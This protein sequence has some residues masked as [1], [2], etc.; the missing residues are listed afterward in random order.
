MLREVKKHEM[1]KH[2]Y[3][4]VELERMHAEKNYCLNDDDEITFPVGE[5]YDFASDAKGLV[6]N[7]AKFGKYD[8]EYI[9]TYISES[10]EKLSQAIPKRD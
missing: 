10:W 6:E 2:F 1:E 8:Y 4:L 9:N 5:V 7:F 3:A